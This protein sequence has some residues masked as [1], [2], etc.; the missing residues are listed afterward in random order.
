MNQIF[1][2]KPQFKQ[3]ILDGVKT[4]TTREDTPFRRKCKV[5][6]IMYMYTGVRTDKMNKFA[7]AKVVN[8]YVWKTEFPE[9]CP[10]F[11]QDWDQFVWREGFNNLEELKDWF[12][13]K[14][15]T[16]HFKVIKKFD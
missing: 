12:C 11:P 7:E 5:G 3:L 9:L 15:I 1:G 6:D 2:F 13:K 16:Y 10:I 14:L 8:I 4:H